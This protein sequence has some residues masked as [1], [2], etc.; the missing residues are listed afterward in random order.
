MQN[1]GLANM[2]AYPYVRAAIIGGS[3]FLRIRSLRFKGWPTRRPR[4]QSQPW[5]LRPVV[6]RVPER[7][8]PVAQLLQQPQRRAR[9]GGYILE[10]Q[11]DLD[12]LT[13][14]RG[15]ERDQR[16][17]QPLP[18]ACSSATGEQQMWI[19]HCGFWSG[20]PHKLQRQLLF[21]QQKHKVL[22]IKSF[23]LNILHYFRRRGL[24][25]AENTTVQWGRFKNKWAKKINVK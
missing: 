9:P 7:L 10:D 3:W 12:H 24:Q 22:Q 21:L 13:S 18:W 19:A 11:L 5:Q 2:G 25:L 6:H 8:W 23:M 16:G 14:E 1:L 15:A 17:G 20:I 4:Q